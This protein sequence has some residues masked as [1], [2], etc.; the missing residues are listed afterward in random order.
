MHQKT[1]STSQVA[2]F[3]KFHDLCNQITGCNEAIIK[4]KVMLLGAFMHSFEAV[5]IAA[6]AQRFSIRSVVFSLFEK[7]IC[8]LVLSFG[9]SKQISSPKC[10]IKRLFLC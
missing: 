3:D 8:D 10:C 2:C 9:Y 5:I 7:T 4:K 1:S 6:V